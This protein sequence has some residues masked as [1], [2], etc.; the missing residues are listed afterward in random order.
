MIQESILRSPEDLHKKLTPAQLDKLMS[1]KHLITLTSTSKEDEETNEDEDWLED[2]E[3][4]GSSD[5]DNQDDDSQDG[6]AN[7]EDDSVSRND[8]YDFIP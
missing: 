2:T 7:K 5:D 8:S 6:S 4:G 1:N 3:E